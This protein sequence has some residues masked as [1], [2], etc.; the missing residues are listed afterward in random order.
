MEN[1]PPRAT[2]PWSTRPCTSGAGRFRSTSFSAA[3][4]PDDGD[5][6]LLPAG[7]DARRASDPPASCCRGLSL[8][9]LSLGM[10]ALFLDLEHKLYVWRLYTTFQPT[11]PMS[12]GALD[13][14]ARVPGPLLGALALRVPGGLLRTLAAVEALC[15]RLS[16]ARPAALGRGGEHGSAARSGSTPAS[17]SRPWRAAA[18]EQSA[19]RPAVSRLGPSAAAAFVHMHRGTRPA[20]AA[21][22]APTTAS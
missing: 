3:G 9:L 13:P 20:S 19:P 4:S 17:C 8:V 22:C 12:W 16:R 18:V 10:L 11:S 2:I 1:S 7:A 6:G 5:L 15:D 21:A 14:D